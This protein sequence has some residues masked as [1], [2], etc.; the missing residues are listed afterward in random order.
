MRKLGIGLKGQKILDLGT[1]AGF[2]ARGFA[3]VGTEV[4]AIDPSKELIEQAKLLEEAGGAT[5]I[6]YE[7][8]IAEN[9]QQ[10]NQYF[11]VVAAGQCWHWFDSRK[12]LQEVLRV[13]KPEGKLVITH[14]DWIPLKGNIPELSEKLILK[15]N[16]NWKMHGGNGFYPQWLTQLIG[17]G[18]QGIETFSFDV[19]AEYSHEAW[20][21]R[22]RASAGIA[23][24]LTKEE[25]VQFDEEH[26]KELERMFPGDPLSTT[27]VFCY[28][29]KTLRH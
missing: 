28:Y 25:V 17:A 13:I 27:S 15:Y 11:D 2:V 20:C 9:T 19:M 3:L 12:A 18:F 8:A 24:T 22:V 26:R 4:I 23:A 29:G 14:Y 16:P 6:K 21:G 1:G 10:P 7:I 5:R